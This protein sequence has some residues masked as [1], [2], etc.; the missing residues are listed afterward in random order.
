[1]EHSRQ[2][3]VVDNGFFERDGAGGRHDRVHVGVL[4]ERRVTGVHG[5]DQHDLERSTV[6]ARGV[7]EVVHTVD[8]ELLPAVLGVDL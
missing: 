4:G 1:M 6:T 7:D 2:H 3:G 5:V 8:R